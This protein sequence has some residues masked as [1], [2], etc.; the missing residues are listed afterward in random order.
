MASSGA[1]Q[2]ISDDLENAEVLHKDPAERAA[3]FESEGFPWLHVVD[4]NGAFEGHP[5]NVE[6]VERIL[7]TVK[8]PVQLSGGMRSMGTIEKWLEK[9]VARSSSQARR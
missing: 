5:V 3:L 2:G 7:R 1:L 6:P 4:L 8:I 9:G